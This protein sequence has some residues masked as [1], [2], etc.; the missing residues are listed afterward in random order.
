MWILVPSFPDPLPPPSNSKTKFSPCIN[1]LKYISTGSFNL[2]LLV[3]SDSLLV[4]LKKTT[5]CQAWQ[6]WGLGFKSFI[7]LSTYQ[8]QCYPE[9]QDSHCSLNFFCQLTIS[10]WLTGDE[11]TFKSLEYFRWP[12]CQYFR[13][14]QIKYLK[15][16]PHHGKWKAYCRRKF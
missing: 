5:W 14:V 13:A 15:N 8:P 16:T 12:D 1:T 9:Y 3:L 6:N 10:R 2:Q 11:L 7:I 4:N